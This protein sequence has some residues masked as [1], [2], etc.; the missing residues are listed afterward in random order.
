MW[1]GEGKCA[2]FGW[3]LAEIM[4]MGHLHLVCMGMSMC[5]VYIQCAK[6]ISDRS[7]IS[8]A[9]VCVLDSHVSHDNKNINIQEIKKGKSYMCVRHTH[10][11]GA[12]DDDFECARIIYNELTE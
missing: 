11:H 2:T 1:F 6:H 9:R 4:D 8:S 10:T 12:Y 5:I 3:L 7:M